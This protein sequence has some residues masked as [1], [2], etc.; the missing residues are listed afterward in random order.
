MFNFLKTL[1]K[2]EPAQS[3]LSSVASGGVQW[4]ET[5]PVVSMTTNGTK[6]LVSTTG[7]EIVVTQTKPNGDIRIQR[8][9]GANAGISVI[10]TKDGLFVNNVKVEF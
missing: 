3:V 5:H 1:F 2:S 8:L 10:Q 7:D 4:P 6:L 9:S